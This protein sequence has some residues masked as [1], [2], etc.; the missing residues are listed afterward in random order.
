VQDTALVDAVQTVQLFYTHADVSFS[1]LFNPRISVPRGAVTV[2]QIA[3][4]YLYDNELYAIEGTGKMVKDAL[5]NAARYYLSCSGDTCLKGP[6]INTRMI[7]YNY[8]MAEGVDYEIDLTQ[9]EGRRI[10][11][12]TWK[13][14]PLAADQKL[15]IALNNY[16]AGGGAGYS[17]FKGA[18]I[19]W[20]SSED[21]RSL[22][23]DYYTEHGQLPVKP[24]GNWRVVPP[25]A[26]R[27]LAGQARDDARR[28]FTR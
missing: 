4:L 1:A 18:K 22:I 19:V 24:S 26:A 9:P 5:E 7:P 15:R 14:R 3:G 2:R 27:T 12:L 16:R 28:V 25:E 6:L 10:R 13:G 11:N 17:M 20:R 21:V 8:D 23:I